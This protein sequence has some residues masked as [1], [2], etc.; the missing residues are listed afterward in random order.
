EDLVNDGSYEEALVRLREL[1]PAERAK[2]PAYYAALEIQTRRQL[3]QSL[4]AAADYDQLWREAV[5]LW[6]GANYDG[7]ILPEIAKLIPL[8]KDPAAAWD[9]LQTAATVLPE[10]T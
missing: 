9:R 5:A 6:R 10:P 7:A 8:L 3:L 4:G 1:S 2:R